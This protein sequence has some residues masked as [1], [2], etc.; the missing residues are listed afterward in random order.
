MK[1]LPME[2]ED[3]AETA[4]QYLGTPPSREV[5]P[6][7][8]NSSIRTLDHDYPAGIA[9]WNHHPEFEIHLIRKSTG[10]FIIGDR[11]GTFGPGHVAL[12]GSDLP[13]DWMSDLQPGEVIHDRDA[14]IQF[15]AKWWDNCVTAMPEL[16][17]VTPLLAE[18]SRGIVFS[19][20]TAVRAAEEIE[21][22]RRTS[23][24]GRMAHL[25]A[26]FVVMASA[27]DEDKQLVASEWFAS[28]TDSTAKAA[29]DAGLAYIFNNLSSRIRMSEAARRALMSESTFSKYFKKASG[30]TFS[31]VVRKLRIANACRLLDGT[32]QS[33]FLISSAVGYDNLANF[34]R[35]FLGEMGLTPSAYRNLPPGSKPQI[36][37]MSLDLK[38]PTDRAGA[39]PAR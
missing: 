6:L 19:G 33:I 4:R 20:D 11:V 28:P 15:D 23:G 32:D 25:L 10:S 13:H 12:I 39:G 3:P 16:A 17:E 24:A 27:S 37:V 30:F 34:N 22:V 21:A 35:Q 18:A 9:H 7:L 2:Y 31:D 29:V 36:P 8:P 1:P 26:L 14:V 5:I 38:A